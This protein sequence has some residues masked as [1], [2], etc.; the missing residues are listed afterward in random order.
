MG[1]VISGNASAGIQ[2]FND[3]TVF[4]GQPIFSPPGV[5][6][7]NAIQGNLI[8]LDADGTGRLGNAQG[9]FINDASGNLV[10]GDAP[11]AGNVVAGNGSIGIQILG[12]NATSNAVLGNTIGTNRGSPRAGQHDR[13]L[14]LRATWECRV[15]LLDARWQHH[16]IQLHR[17]GSGSPVGRRAA[18]R[19]GG[20]SLESVERRD[21]RDR[22]D[23]HDL[24]RQRRAMN[25]ANYIVAT[26]GRNFRPGP[27]I[28]IASVAYD[29]IFRIVTVTF[30]RAV[31]RNTQL[32]LRV[33]GTAPGGLTDRVGNFLEGNPDVVRRNT[34][35][36]FQATFIQGVQVQ[37]AVAQPRRGR[38]LQRGSQGAHSV[39]TR[40][41]KHPGH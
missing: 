37:N 38:L 5:A 31:P 4:D 27:R 19:A 33:V 30:A 25:P 21:S 41:A 26:I 34:G 18:G 11:G 3:A 13:R 36:D 20:P 2:I 15:A 7:G 32:R 22:V 6:T 16:P 23:L 29:E 17:T 39:A 10:G 12:D 8:G 24:R 40:G 1:N 14:H 28:P 9:I 35:S